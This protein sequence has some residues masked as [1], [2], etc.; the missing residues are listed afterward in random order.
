N[1]VNGQLGYPLGPTRPPKLPRLEPGDANVDG[2]PPIP[3]PGDFDMDDFERDFNRY[4]PDFDIDDFERDFNRYQPQEQAV[5]PPGGQDRPSNLT[6]EQTEMMKKYLSK[7]YTAPEL[8]KK[9]NFKHHSIKATKNKIKKNSAQYPGFIENNNPYL[10]AHGNYGHLNRE[11]LYREFKNS[12]SSISALSKKYKTDENIIQEILNDQERLHEHGS[13]DV[14]IIDLT[15]PDPGPAR[16]SDRDIEIAKKYIS[17]MYTAKELAAKYRIPRSMVSQFRNHIISNPDLYPEIVTKPAPWLVSTR[18]YSQINRARLL[19]ESNRGFSSKQL[20]E[21]YGID[22]KIINEALDKARREKN[23][24]PDN[25][26]RND[27]RII[28]HQGKVLRTENRERTLADLSM[29]TREVILQEGRNGWS[30]QQLARRHQIPES[31]I[32][33]LAADDDVNPGRYGY[34]A[35]LISRND[36]IDIYNIAQDGEEGVRHASEEYG[37]TENSVRRIVEHVRRHA[38]NGDASNLPMDLD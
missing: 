35:S 38:P 21:Q 26:R 31:I 19:S 29:E 24:A 13:A 37:L 16:L 12:D 1:R 27:P 6:A 3:A 23:D 33:D 28:A 17:K 5:E 14:D 2:N 9:Y 4:Q 8:E 15:S 32:D 22:E 7:F 11:M 18:N 10:Y 30:R 34:P 36:R 20:S 25:A